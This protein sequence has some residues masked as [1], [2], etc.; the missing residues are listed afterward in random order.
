MS[1]CGELSDEFKTVVGVLQ[2]CVL[3]LLLFNI[4][5]EL[6]IARALEDEEIGGQ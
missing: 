2:R 5:P 6:I 4:F 1:H 3:S